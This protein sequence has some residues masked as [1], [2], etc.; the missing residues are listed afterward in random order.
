VA[1]GSW[2]PPHLQ[3][4]D[5]LLRTATRLEDAR[6]KVVKVLLTAEP[7]RLRLASAARA[8]NEA[9]AEILRGAALDEEDAPEED[10]CEVDMTYYEQSHG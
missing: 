5:A 6:R 3:R 1:A 9:A 10:L 7:R 4:I 8:A 2:L